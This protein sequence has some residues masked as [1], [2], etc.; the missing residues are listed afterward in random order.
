MQSVS[1]SNI[2]ADFVTGDK[3][4]KI[5]KEIGNDAVYSL[6]T[7]QLVRFLDFVGCEWSRV[8]V[9][10]V[11]EM[12]LNNHANLTSEQWQLFYVKAKNGHFG[13]I[14]GKFTPML[15]LKWANGFAAECDKANE[16]YQ[17]KLDRQVKECDE[18]PEI[19]NFHEKLI[20][21]INQVQTKEIDNKNQRV[22][23]KRKEWEAQFKAHFNK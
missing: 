9:E 21:C 14:Y 20:E 18:A 16:E 7:K 17:I 13:D 23:E 15:F 1:V 5:A 3:L 8:Q 22:S 12:I 6:V 11:V 10:D 2:P 19:P 4:Y